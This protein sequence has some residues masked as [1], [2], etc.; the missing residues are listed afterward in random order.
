MNEKITGERLRNLGARFPCSEL[1]ELYLAAVNLVPGDQRHSY[2]PLN[3]RLRRPHAAVCH[4][5]NSFLK[6]T[7]GIFRLRVGPGI[8]D[9]R[10]IRS[11]LIFGAY[12]RLNY[13]L[14]TAVVYGQGGQNDLK[15]TRKYGKR[16]RPPHDVYKLEGWR[17][18]R[19]A[20]SEVIG[21][22]TVPV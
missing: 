3:K 14:R 10:T 15:W 21:R 1:R 7:H 6:N 4:V 5:D 19:T 16:L 18:S 11:T 17:S 2:R 8:S 13:I 22:K 12:P 9:C 20:T